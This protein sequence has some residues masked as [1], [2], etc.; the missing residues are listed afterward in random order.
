MKSRVKILFIAAMNQEIPGLLTQLSSTSKSGSSPGRYYSGMYHG[1]DCGALICGVGGE[2]ATR[3]LMHLLESVEPVV[4]VIIGW[5]GSL[6]DELNRGDILVIKWLNHCEKPKNLRLN[7][8][9]KMQEKI[10]TALTSAGHAVKTGS[11]VTSDEVVFRRE[12]RNHLFATYEADCVEMESYYLESLLRKNNIPSG[13]VRVISDTA[14]ERIGVDL[15]GIPENRK[16]RM[17]YWARHPVSFK[18]YLTL[19]S[20]LRH[21]SGVMNRI[22]PALIQM[23]I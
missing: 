11:L 22:L 21:A 5:A 8:D 10:Q 6:R 23:C 14:D 3:S 20:D 2:K 17:L 4:A 12:H 19:L 18:N 1:V 9:P 15:T 16:E 7:A 13:V